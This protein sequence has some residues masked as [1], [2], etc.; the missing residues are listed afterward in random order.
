M[1]IINERCD[2]M[3]NEF[4]VPTGKIIKEY[5]DEYN[6]SQKELAARIGMSEKHISNLLNGSSRITE[7]FSLKLEKVLTD[8]PASYW[9]NYETKYREEL[10]RQNELLKL[11]QQNLKVVAKKF[12][13]KE[14]FKGLDMSLIEQAVEMLKL[15]KISDFNNFDSAYKNL[16]VDFMEDGGAKEPI[17][18]WLK[19]C[20]SEIEIQNDDIENISYN[21]KNLKNSL[22]KFKMLSNNDNVELSIKSCRKLCNK[23]GIYFVLCEAV[24]NSKVRGALTTYKGHPAIFLSGRFKSH[25]NI[26]FAFIHEIGHLL[27]H[28]NKK[29]IIISYEDSSED[30]INNKEAEANKFA[31]DFF[32]NQED[33]EEY[34]IKNNFTADSIKKFANLQ[35]ILPGIVVARLQHDGKVGYDQF[36][37]LK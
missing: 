1:I 16:E 9:L 15:L 30:N 10:A 28:Y 3:S 4:I 26:W 5:L 33:Y 34:L 17:A 29:D 23:L 21:E 12:Y 27:K 7:E 25:D 11:S 8:I 31:R 32:I 6:V 36:V 19:L 14:V 20:E 18:I 22:D 37:Y 13:F 2:I 35:G 24:T